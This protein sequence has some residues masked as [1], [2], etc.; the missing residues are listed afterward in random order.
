MNAEEILPI[1]EGAQGDQAQF[2][3]LKH[4]IGAMIQRAYACYRVIGAGNAASASMSGD[5]F[6]HAHDTRSHIRIPTF[7]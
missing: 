5:H 2:Q 3:A 1:L 4:V 7:T 6:I